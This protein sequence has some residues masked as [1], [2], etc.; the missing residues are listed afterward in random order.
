MGAVELAGA[1]ADPHH[2]GRAVEPVTG[3]RVHP[4][5]ALLVGEDQ[6]LVARPEV[7]LVQP[8]FSAQVDAACRHEAKGPVDFRCHPL[9]AQPFG[10]RGHELLVPQMDLGEV[11]E[12]TFGEGAQQVER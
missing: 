4:G 11:G 8:H 1:V 9:V 5:Q 2:V 3:Q 10:R 12:A 7:D 6:C